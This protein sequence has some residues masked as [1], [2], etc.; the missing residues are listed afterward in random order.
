VREQ[1]PR[2]CF[3]AEFRD[4]FVEGYVDYLDRGGNAQP[5]VVPPIRYT[6]NHY[7]TPDGH[8]LV[9]DY[10]LGFRYGLDVAVASGHRQYLVVPVLVPERSPGPPTFNIQP[11]GAEPPDG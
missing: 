2:K 7:L 9:K 3:T 1:F 4:G 6:R 10:F 8:L 11:H 5:P